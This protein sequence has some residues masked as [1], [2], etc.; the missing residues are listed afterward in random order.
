MDALT[1][2][3]CRQAQCTGRLLRLLP[4]PCLRRTFLHLPFPRVA[5]HAAQ[6]ALHRALQTASAPPPPLRRAPLPTRRRCVGAMPCQID[7]VWLQSRVSSAP[8]LFVEVSQADLAA[9][10]RE[11]VVQRRPFRSDDNTTAS[12]HPFSCTVRRRREPPWPPR[13]RPPPS[14]TFRTC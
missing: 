9:E 8:I 10:V 1:Q 4:Q 7:A 11:R 12:E 13:P 14:R 3:R 6:L 2:R 5:V